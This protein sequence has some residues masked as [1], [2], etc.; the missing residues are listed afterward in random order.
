MF[1]FLS[2]RLVLLPQVRKRVYD[3]AKDDV[4][5]DGVDENKERRC[6]E[7]PKKDERRKIIPTQSYATQVL[8]SWH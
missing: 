6:V 7:D 8:Q 3:D 1:H 4:D 2:H 5:Q